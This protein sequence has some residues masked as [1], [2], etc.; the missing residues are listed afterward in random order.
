M[1]RPQDPRLVLDRPIEWTKSPCLSQTSTASGVPGHQHARRC[2]CRYS[3]L[4]AH[5]DRIPVCAFCRLRPGGDRQPNPV[6][7]LSGTAGIDVARYV[8][9]HSGASPAARFL[10]RLSWWNRVHVCARLHTG[11]SAGAQRCQ[12]RHRGTERQLPQCQV[13]GHSLV[14]PRVRA[15]ERSRCDHR[16]AVYSLYFIPVCDHLDRIRLGVSLLHTTRKAT[17]S[18]VRS[19]LLPAPCAGLLFG[20][21]GLSM[22]APVERLATRLGG[23][24][25]PCALVCIGFFLAQERVVSDD[26]VSIGILALLKLIVQ[27]TITAILALY[28][29]KMPPLWSHAAVLLSALPIGSRAIY[30]RQAVWPGGGGHLGCDPRVA[31]F[32]QWSPFRSWLP[33]SPN[34]SD[35]RGPPSYQ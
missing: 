14:F 30:D 28:V 23:A 29:F 19:P 26:F 7:R 15:R 5:L 32:S 8:Q 11:S 9:E 20:L 21:S 25:S 31:I 13:H 18:L 12:R 6:C 24:A 10:R 3:D 34:I 22:P 16:Y 1:P 33:G 35:K 2:E 4:R 27:P 17:L